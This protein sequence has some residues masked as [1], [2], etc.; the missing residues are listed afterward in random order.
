M[1]AVALSCPE[2]ND[3][4]TLGSSKFFGASSV[5][6]LNTWEENNT[7]VHL[8]LSTHGHL[9]TLTSYESLYQLLPTA[10]RSFSDEGSKYINLWG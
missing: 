10:K 4:P 3:L 7:G 8:S 1:S 2:D 6:F 5:M 9:V